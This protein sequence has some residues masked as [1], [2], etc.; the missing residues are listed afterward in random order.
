MT[1][2]TFDSTHLFHL[3]IFFIHRQ[4]M[5]ILWGQQWHHNDIVMSNQEIHCLFNSLFRLTTKETTKLP[6]TG[7]LR[8]ESSGH[9]SIPLT[10]GQ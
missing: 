7:P 6:I 9:R 3:F 8:G 5:I 1:E 10:K 2:H 4:L